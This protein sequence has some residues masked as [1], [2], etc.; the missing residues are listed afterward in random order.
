M[1]FCWCLSNLLQL[2]VAIWC[3][4]IGVLLQTGIAW[5]VMALAE[6]P[7]PL[8]KQSGEGG[9]SWPR[10]VPP[11]WPERP[12]TLLVGQGLGLMVHRYSSRHVAQGGAE[13]LEIYQLDE[14]SAGLPFVCFRWRQPL[15]MK[16]SSTA[17]V[18]LQ[19][20]VGFLERGLSLSPGRW[21]RVGIDPI[22]SG[23]V[24][25]VFAFWML[26][27][28][29]VCAWTLGRRHVRRHR[30]RC[31]QCGYQIGELSGCPECGW[32]APDMGHRR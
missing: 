31:I 1:P 14:V 5:T 7:A 13:V 17:L 29:I 20:H 23:F 6:W 25:N 8:Q 4:L 27:F 16:S 11:H 3:A 10:S 9:L 2:R 30:G 22:W 24:G 26:C 21:N 28:S 19:S 15:A 32:P 18:P 12:S